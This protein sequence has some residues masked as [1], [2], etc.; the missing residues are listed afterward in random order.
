[1]EDRRLAGLGWRFLVVTRRAYAQAV[2]EFL[3][4]FQ[5]EPGRIFNKANVQKYKADL[6]IKGLASSSIN[7]RLAALRR[8]AIEAAD[9][10][11]IAPELAAGIARAKGAKRCR[12]RF[13]R[14]LSQRQ[15]Q[16]LLK[17]QM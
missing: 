5:D 4:W 6:E 15:T 12:V 2:Y 3:I 17:L 13:G 7:V 10:G 16:Q 1:M 14:W 8:L 9:N 11:L